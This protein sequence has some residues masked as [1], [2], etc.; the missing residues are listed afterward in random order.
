MKIVI[1]STLA[2][3][4]LG[5]PSKMLSNLRSCAKHRITPSNSETKDQ[6]YY[7]A[8][9]IDRLLKDKDYRDDMLTSVPGWYLTNPFSSEPIWIEVKEHP[10]FELD[11]ED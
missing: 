8:Q 9:G 4:R 1:P 3:Q 5:I 6:D 11:D 7:Y 2:A 10:S